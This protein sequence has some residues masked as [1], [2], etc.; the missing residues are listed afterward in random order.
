MMKK[1]LVMLL[2]AMMTFSVVAC[3]GDDSTSDA[4]QQVESNDEQQVENNDEQQVENNDE[5]DVSGDYTDAQWALVEKY[6]QMLDDYNAMAEVARNTP[7]L[8][9]DSELVDVMNELAAEID[10]VTDTISDPEVL[11]DDVIASVEEFIPQVY[12]VINRMN[13]LAELLPI[14]TT[15][16]VGADEEENTYWFACND[17]VTVA[18]MLILSADMSEYVSC[19]GDVVDNG[20]GTLTITEE[21]YT[22]TFAVEEVEDGLILTMQDGTQVAMIPATPLEVVDMMISIEEG[23]T[24]V[25]EG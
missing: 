10:N 12:T 8:M 20:D 9:E 2:C 18:A 19:V 4:G 21:N 15:A 1:L 13:T 25:N 14:L 6:Q 16:G 22:M 7:A 5:A 23:V 3:G 17:D 24:N 11:T